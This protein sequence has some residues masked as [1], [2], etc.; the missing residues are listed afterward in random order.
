MKYIKI[1]EGIAI[2]KK[3]AWIGHIEEK[4]ECEEIQG[5]LWTRIFIKENAKFFFKFGDKR[6]SFT[7]TCEAKEKVIEEWER[8]LKLINDNNEGK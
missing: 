2:N 1:L 5:F 4:P 3:T 6:Q 7:T 8:V